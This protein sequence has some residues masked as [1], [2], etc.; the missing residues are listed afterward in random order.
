L[1]PGAQ[2][3][4]T[5]RGI[6]LVLSGSGTVDDTPFRAMTA[7]YLDQDEHTRFTADE[8]S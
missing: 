7:V 5:G 2:L 1:A 6:N 4:V 3:T 8:G